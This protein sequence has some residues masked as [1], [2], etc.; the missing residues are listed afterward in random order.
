M[1]LALPEVIFDFQ[2]QFGYSP[3]TLH[4][5][6]EMDLIADT[7]DLVLDSTKTKNQEFIQEE[8]ELRIIPLLTMMIADSY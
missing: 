5:Y 1:C 7:T 8:K 3:K 6:E 4:W 2:H